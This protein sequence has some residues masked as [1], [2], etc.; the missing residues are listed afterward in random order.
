[1]KNFSESPISLR[2]NP[3]KKCKGKE[4]VKEIKIID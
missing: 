1:M 3:G 2:I 4:I